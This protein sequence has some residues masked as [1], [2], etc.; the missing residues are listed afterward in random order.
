[1]FPSSLFSCKDIK[2]LE[3]DYA[4]IYFNNGGGGQPLPFGLKGLHPLILFILTLFFVDLCLLEKSPFFHKSHH[5]THSTK[6]LIKATF[7]RGIQGLGDTYLSNPLQKM[8]LKSKPYKGYSKGGGNKVTWI[9]FG[10]L[11]TSCSRPRFGLV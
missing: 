4:S 11:N 2:T 9:V 5:Q 1:M 7:S 6:D 3:R 8:F 10:S